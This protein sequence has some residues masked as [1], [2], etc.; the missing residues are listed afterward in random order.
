MI[1]N[2]FFSIKLIRQSRRGQKKFPGRTNYRK[3]ALSGYCGSA[4]GSSSSFRNYSWG[5]DP[6]KTLLVENLALTLVPHQMFGKD[7][8][9]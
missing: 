8:E 3:Y 5:G 4:T 6:V 9:S 2:I 7:P 1:L